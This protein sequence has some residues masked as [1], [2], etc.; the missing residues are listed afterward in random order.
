MSITKTF[1]AGIVFLSVLTCSRNPAGPDP[2]EGLIAY[3]P[4][5]GNTNDESGNGNTGIINGGVTFTS[6]RSGTAASACHFDGTGKIN[7]ANPAGCDSLFEFSFCAWFKY[8]NTTSSYP[9]IISADT[10]KFYLEVLGDVYQYSSP[11]YHKIYVCMQGNTALYTR[12]IEMNKWYFIAVSFD[13]T[14]TAVYLMDSTLVTVDKRV[15]TST[16][17]MGK[18][19]YFDIGYAFS[20]A[21]IADPSCFITGLVDE[22]RI[23]KRALSMEEVYA[24]YE[25]G[26]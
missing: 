7:I 2:N 14:N 19:R 23:Y 26:T 5:N 15:I 6:D 3:Y 10:N 9:S 11:N 12:S 20:R 1:F 13:G 4:F 22:V 24:L 21:S 8:D 16:Q 18:V 17:P 25:G